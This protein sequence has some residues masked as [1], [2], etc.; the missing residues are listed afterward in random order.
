M[1][2]HEMSL[3]ELKRHKLMQRPHVVILGA[4]ASVA[5][6]PQGD[7]NGIRLPVMLNLVAM[8]GLESVLAKAGLEHQG[9]NFEDIYNQL[10]CD[11]SLSDVREV[12]EQCVAEYFS[13][14]KLP[15]H[16]T[17]YDYLVLSLRKKD[18]IATF[19]WDPFLWLACQR[20]Q[21]K[22]QLPHIFF[23][24]GC[25]IIGHCPEHKMQGLVGNFC[26]ACSRRYAPT[27]LLYPVA[28][29]D[30]V[31]DPYI[32]SQWRSLRGA[33]QAAYVLTIFG[34]GAPESDAAA[35]DLMSEAWGSPEKRDL[36]EIELIDI[37]DQG[38]L[39]ATWSRFIHTHHVRTTKSYFESLLGAFPRRTCEAMWAE[40]MEVKFLEYGQVPKFERLDE[41]WEWFQQLMTYEHGASLSD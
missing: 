10:S 9:R 25:A 3:E 21:D 15:E 16:P 2:D 38:E 5:A 4:G 22:T 27:R 39:E 7:C 29:K 26:P 40:L 34:Y 41:M 13:K 23:L 33:L 8:L 19:N 36:E 32:A 14:L 1:S 35:V 28:N 18:V 37:K 12:V 20:N 31:T 24:H 6:L 30:Y 17:L 11:A